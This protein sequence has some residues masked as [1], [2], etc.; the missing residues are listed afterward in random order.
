MDYTSE[1]ANE[2]D[3]PAAEDAPAQ[4]MMLND[5]TSGGNE[6]MGMIDGQPSESNDRA[7]IGEFYKPNHQPQ[8]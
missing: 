4:N 8:T 1:A 5:E 3:S 6:V 2:L 7:E